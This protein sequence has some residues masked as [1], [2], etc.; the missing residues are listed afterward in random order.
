MTT[1]EAQATEAAARER[2]PIIMVVS[3]LLLAI[4]LNAGY[5]TWLVQTSQHRWCA[6]IG[7]LNNAAKGAP[8]PQTAYGRHLVQ[9]FHD[10]YGGLGCG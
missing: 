4:M 9:D 5:T 7:T 1:P 3:A 6:T 8:A 2:R 10:L